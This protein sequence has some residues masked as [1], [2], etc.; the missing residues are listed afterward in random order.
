M[1]KFVSR[2]KKIFVA[3]LQSLYREWWER[4]DSLPATPTHLMLGICIMLH[5]FRYSYSQRLPSAHILHR[6][7]LAQMYLFEYLLQWRQMSLPLVRY[8]HLLHF[9]YDKVL[10]DTTTT[11]SSSSSAEVTDDDL[12]L[13]DA[14]HAMLLSLSDVFRH[15]IPVLTKDE[16]LFVSL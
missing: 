8:G 5:I 14:E 10:F 3:M 2:Q 4:R 13:T 9:I 11:S 7:R 16:P 6:R 1:E 12:P 15:P